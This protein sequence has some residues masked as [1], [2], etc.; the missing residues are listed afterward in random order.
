[1]IAQF[2]SVVVALSAARE[3][4]VVLVDCQSLNVVLFFRFDIH[5]ALALF[6]I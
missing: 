6:D 5:Y 1:M 3:L 2:W 4:V